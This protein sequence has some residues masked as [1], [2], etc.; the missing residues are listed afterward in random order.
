MTLVQLEYLV[1]I[2]TYGNFSIAAKKCFVTQPTLSMQIR[3]IED[4]LEVKIFDRSKKPVIATGIGSEIIKIAKEII[5][6]TKKISELISEQ[7]GKIR[8]ELKLAIIPTIAP[9]LVPLFLRKYL[10]TYPEI[11]LKVVELTTE[12][13]IDNLKKNLIDVGILVTPISENSI[14]TIPLYYEEFVLYISK[15]DQLLSKDKISLDDIDTRKL[16]LLEEGHCFRTQMTNLCDRKKTTKEGKVFQYEAGSIETLKR[17][18][19]RNNGITILP[20]LAI[21]DFK[22]SQLKQIRR[23]KAPVPVREVSLVTHRDYIK[24]RLIDVLKKE[25]IDCLPKKILEEKKKDIINI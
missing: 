16:W 7:K 25:I 6:G 20:E 19:E 2:E 18:V 15:T 10:Q 14:K 12:K 4:E 13:I 9:Y 5:A 3:K 22:P 21:M 24:K 23:F 1:A 11:S 17:M 8:G